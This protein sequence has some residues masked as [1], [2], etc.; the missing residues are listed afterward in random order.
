MA[1]TK[2]TTWTWRCNKPGCEF[3]TDV[4]D[5]DAAGEAIRF[6]K[7]SKLPVIDLV[8]TVVP[9]P[10]FETPQP[11]ALW[12]TG[13]V[14][15]FFCVST[16]HVRSWISDVLRP[17]RGGRVKGRLSH[18]RFRHDTVELLIPVVQLPRKALLE[19]LYGV[20]RPVHARAQALMP[21]LKERTA[22]L[23][24]PHITRQQEKLARFLE[25]R[26]EDFYE[27][28]ERLLT[29]ETA[30]GEGFYITRDGVTASRSSLDPCRCCGEAMDLPQE[31]TIGEW[32]MIVH[33][34]LLSAHS[35]E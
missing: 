35:R 33:R 31:A 15:D 27:H 24:E 23:L 17:V 10:R 32:A 7:R 25:R 13:Q 29:E 16:S 6:H 22:E 30:V 26:E 19:I 1:K 3:T 4:A 28:V 2:G 9:T 14:A 8:A 20:R 12:T 18:Y 5:V 34:H 21:R 11:S